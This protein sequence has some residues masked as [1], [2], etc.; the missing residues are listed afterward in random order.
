MLFLSEC[1]QNDLW[2]VSTSPLKTAQWLS[3]TFILL[4]FNV[5]H[6]SR[7]DTPDTLTLVTLAFPS[8]PLLQ[9]TNA[10]LL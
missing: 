7:C 3:V 10:L 8:P 2:V 4:V 9:T 6:W 1:S 5:V